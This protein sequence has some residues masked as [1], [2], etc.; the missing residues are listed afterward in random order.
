MWIQN[1]VSGKLKRVII[2]DVFLYTPSH[3]VSDLL[4]KKQKK[5]VAYTSRA[6]I[7]LS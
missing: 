7:S 1:Y 4:C 3:P 5:W 6:S 2:F